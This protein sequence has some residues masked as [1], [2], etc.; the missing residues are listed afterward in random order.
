MALDTT[1][2]STLDLVE[3]WPYEFRYIE[4][5]DPIYNYLSIFATELQRLDAFINELYDQRFIETATGPE[6]ERLGAEVGVTREAGESDEVFRFR[7]KLGAAVAASD[8]TADDIAD[9]L[10]LAFDDDTLEAITVEHINGDPLTQ[11]TI[12]SHAIESIPLTK[13]EL[14]TEIQ[15]AFPCGHVITIVRD[16]TF[17]FGGTGSQSLGRGGL[18]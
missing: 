14:E 2:T 9:I 15:Q 10:A 1:D 4:E 5:T 11:F 7:V 18:S 3:N 12:P 17:V 6:L 8:G 16:D 13:T